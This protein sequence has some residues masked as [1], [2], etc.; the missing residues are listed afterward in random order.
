MEIEIPIERIHANKDN[1]NRHNKEEISQLARNIKKVG[2]LNAITVR[3]LG[4]D[5]YEIV[6][7]EG[8]YHALHDLGYEKV[9]CFILE[10]TLTKE[11]LT[12]ARLSENKM[13]RWDW[14]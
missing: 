9:R 12:V 14:I 3:P 8:R 1:Q 5:H 6:A 7:G 11:K 13:R 2:L 10:R 4:H